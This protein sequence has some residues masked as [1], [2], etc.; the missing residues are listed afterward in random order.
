LRDRLKSAVEHHV[1][2]PV[3]EVSVDTQVAP[4]AAPSKRRRRRVE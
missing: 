3:A 4:L 2:L 1:G